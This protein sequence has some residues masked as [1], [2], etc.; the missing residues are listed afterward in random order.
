MSQS[1][2]SGKRVKTGLVSLFLVILVAGASAGLMDQ[3]AGEIGKYVI[4]TDA[5]SSKWTGVS[6]EVGQWKDI[7]REPVYKLNLD[8]SDSGE[9]NEIDLPGRLRDP[10]YYAAMPVTGEK[11]N[12]TKL[13][14]TSLQDVD[15]GQLFPENSYPEFYPNYKDLSDAP[16]E[17]FK[18]K[19]EIKVLDK[20][21]TALKTSLQTGI[22]YYLL[23]YNTGGEEHPVFIVDTQRYSSCYSGGSCNF[24]FLLPMAD[25][26]TYSFYQLATSDPINMT[27]WINGDKSSSFKFPGR[28]YR[29]E[30]KTKTVFGEKLTD[31]NI[32]VAE[33]NGNNLFLPSGFGEAR[34][35][36]V[37]SSGHTQELLVT[38]TGYQTGENYSLRL[39]AFKSDYF[40]RIE[41]LEIGKEYLKPGG[42]SPGDIG[43]S[44]FSSRYKENVNQLRSV[45]DCASHSLN[46]ETAFKLSV[47]S[48]G[49]KKVVRGRPYLVEVDGADKYSI[50]ENG[51]ILLMSPSGQDTTVHSG[52]NFSAGEKTLFIPTKREGNISLKAFNSSGGKVFE[53]EFEL[54]PGTCSSVRDGVAVS[55]DSRRVGERINA[56]KQLLN[57]MYAAGKS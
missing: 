3:L 22:D 1:T 18:Q 27:T 20:K 35:E 33:Q 13:A 55:F 28:P 21:Y 24:Q 51:S 31:A 19:A 15:K 45:F 57:S 53:S 49:T 30:V 9:V 6:G 43:L 41:Q 4:S 47:S 50:A 8:S 25:T 48:G 29:L 40:T 42:P 26:S 14:N 56:V 46:Q 36:T 44:Q 5:V 32:S 12:K 7:G 23:K 52:G 16:D 17:T 2:V 10:Y 34:L 37:S 54:V 11:F 38:P 39:K